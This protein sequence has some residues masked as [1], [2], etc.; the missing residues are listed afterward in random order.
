MSG[1]VA[2]PVWYRRSDGASHDRFADVVETATLWAADEYD[3]AL[4]GEPFDA[5]G[6]RTATPAAFR[7]ALARTEIRHG[8]GET[9][10]PLAD[11]GNVGVDPTETDVATVRETLRQYTARIYEHAATPIFFGGDGTLTCSNV[12]PLLEQ[13][14]VGV[15]RFGST[16]RADGDRTDSAC[17]SYRRL[18]SAGLDA[19]AVVGTRRD[20]HVAGEWEPL[21]GRDWHAMSMAVVDDGPT[22]AATDALASLGDVDA[23]FASVD[24]PALEASCARTG[25]MVARV[26]ADPR[27]AGVEVIAEESEPEPSAESVRA[28]ARTVAHFLLGLEERP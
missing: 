28:G 1:L 12:A 21:Y 13:G 19:M 5:A 4:V 8:D 2:P 15:V 16:I 10:A 27:I 18:F 25:S 11:L 9:A 22:A 26:A 7:E 20:E 3:A 17:D 23:V 14:R 24:L 6:A